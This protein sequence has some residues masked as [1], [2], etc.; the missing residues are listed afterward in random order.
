MP[1]AGTEPI[2]ERDGNLSK[3]QDQ[4]RNPQ[5]DIAIAQ[6]AT[7]RPILDVA[8][9]KLGIQPAQLSPYGHYKAKLSLDYVKSL[10][11][12]PDGKLILATAITPTPAGQAKTTT[13][14]RPA[15]PP[16]PLAQ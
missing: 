8:R 15:A 16:T 7:M 1:A 10:D 6:A 4:H 11:S 3:G 2:E 9:D 12:K 14:S 5:S 13:P